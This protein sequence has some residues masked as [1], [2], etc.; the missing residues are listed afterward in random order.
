MEVLV[1]AEQIFNVNSGFY[2]SVDSD[3]LYNAEDMN[4]PYKRLVSNGVFATNT[5]TVSSDLQVVSANDGMKIICKAGE[6][7]FNNK[8]FQSPNDI[9]ITVE[10]NTTLI[11]RIDSIIVQVDVSLSGRIGSIV[12]RTGTQ[13]VPPINTDAEKIEYRIA[14]IVVNPNDINIKQSAI[15]DLRGSSSCPWVTGL[16]KQVDTSTL[17][18]QWQAAYRQYYD[19]ETERF[20]SFVDD[21][22]D[23]LGV[24]TTIVQVKSSY[25][26]VSETD[27]IPIDIVGFNA[28]EDCLIVFLN[29]MIQ[30]ED[31]KY[32]LDDDTCIFTNPLP[33]DQRVDFVCLK[34]V[35][36]TDV[37]S[38]TTLLETIEQT[39][40]DITADTGWVDVEFMEDVHSYSLNLVKI[41]KINNKVY[42]KGTVQVVFDAQNPITTLFTVPYYNTNA[43]IKIPVPNNELI[44]SKT[45]TVSV[46]TALSASSLLNIYCEYFVD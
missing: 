14:N 34:S 19:T 42:L 22:V 39:V 12:Y 31:I 18:D 40:S 44:I 23:T 17:Y 26:T 11:T 32:T 24:N 16:I 20:T 37:K 30:L 3:R 1:M 36:G 15:T 38:A 25:T 45:G 21:L 35:V 10:S 41:R 27:T 43:N 5:G 46:N 4:K 29:G 9:V 13:T 28:E 8:W 7:I 33:I 6:G 2:N